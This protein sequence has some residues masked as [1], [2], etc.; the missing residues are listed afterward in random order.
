MKNSSQ[1]VLRN[2]RSVPKLAFEHQ[3]L[4]SFAGFVLFWQLF[5]NLRL[6]PRLEACFGA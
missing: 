4:T 1:S 6:L 5:K 2:Y 3:R